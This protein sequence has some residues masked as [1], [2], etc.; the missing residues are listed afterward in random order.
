MADETSFHRLIEP[1]E[2][3]KT[4]S[5]LVSSESSGISGQTIVVNGP[6]A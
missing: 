5:W 4:C 1:Q 3:A 6:V 2:V